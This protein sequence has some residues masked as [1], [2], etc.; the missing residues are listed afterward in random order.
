M[1]DQGLQLAISAAGG[2]ASLAKRLGIAQPSVSNWTRIPSDRVLTVEYLTGVSRDMLRPDLYA[3]KISTGELA[4]LDDVD[5]ARAQEYLLLGSL[6]RQAPVKA[7]LREIGSMQGD[8]TVLGLLHMSL[9][10]AADETDATTESREFFRLFIGV[11]RGELLPYGSYYQTGFL[12]ERPLARVREDLAR[13]GI[14][15]SSALSEPEDHIGIL[16]DVM[17]GLITGQ[18]EANEYEQEKFFS[19]H[20]KPWATRLFSDMEACA[21][22]PFYKAAARVGV[23]FIDIETAG[24]ALPV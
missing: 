19:A 9:A 5:Q 12:H 20:I 13:L 14:E 18:F 17:A 11:G 15:R 4:V 10:E 16:F 24:F 6:M 7:L 23:A 21:K 1:R 2:V 8:A 22:T 3:D